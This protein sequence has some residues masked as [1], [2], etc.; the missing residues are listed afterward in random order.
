M[1]VI[2]LTTSVIHHR[3]SGDGSIIKLCFLRLD[4]MSYDTSVYGI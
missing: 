3:A 2:N 4:V 1:T